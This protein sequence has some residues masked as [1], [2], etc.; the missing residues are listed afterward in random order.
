MISQ[1]KR[2]VI[3]C[4]HYWSIHNQSSLSGSGCSPRAD[5]NSSHTRPVC[6]LR[7]ILSV[8]DSIPF[9]YCLDTI[10]FQM[11]IPRGTIHR[12]TSGRA[13]TRTVALFVQHLPFSKQ[14]FDSRISK[15]KIFIDNSLFDDPFIN[16]I[17]ISALQRRT[18]RL[19][20]SGV[21]RFST[22]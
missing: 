10:Q 3:L 6:I 17:Y 8:P 12:G 2:K 18:S 14:F 4:L 1:Q 9:H 16:K 22:T 20:S 7:Q 15:R 5:I 21:F 19:Q 11:L 13:I